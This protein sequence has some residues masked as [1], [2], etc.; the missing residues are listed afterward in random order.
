MSELEVNLLLSSAGRRPYLVEWFQNALKMNRVHG[1][2]LVTDSDPHAPSRAF[3]D[4]FVVAPAVI[5]SNYEA[6]LDTLL[7]T[8][9]IDL[10]ISLNDFELSKWANFESNLASAD[11]LLRLAPDTQKVVEDKLQAALCLRTN[12]VPVPDTRTAD[13]VLDNL[14]NSH[15]VDFVTKGRFGS[16]SRGLRFATSSGL[17]SAVSEAV[18][19]V[20]DPFGLKAD[21]TDPRSLGLIVVQPHIHGQ[22]FGI[23]VVCDLDGQYVTTLARRKIAMRAGET[24]RAESVDA[25]PFEALGR[26]IAKAIPHRGI[27][28]VDVI[29]DTNENPWVIDINPRFGGGYPFS[30]LAG[31]NIP[32]AYV[33]WVLNADPEPNW[34][35]SKAGVISSK[36]VGVTRTE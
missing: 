26:Q 5:N 28:D 1:R 35:T 29:I 15:A 22:E 25:A 32:A 10:A 30:H 3:A 4:H 24:D 9:R 33:A 20:T 16:A 2:I 18:Q 31:A 21:P 23:D 34:L 12:G 11:R 27:I 6:W 14:T 8:E 7:L 13:E 19:E 17:P 36:F